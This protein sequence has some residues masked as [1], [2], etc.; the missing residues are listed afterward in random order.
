MGVSAERPVA[1]R[2]LPASSFPFHIVA[3]GH[4]DEVLWEETV[5]GPC[6]LEVPGFH[7]AVKVVRVTF[8]DGR[9]EESSS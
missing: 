6:A 5:T 2:D 4:D 9:V 7:G 1:F 3:L 8:A